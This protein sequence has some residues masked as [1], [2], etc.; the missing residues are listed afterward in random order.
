GVENERH[1][2]VR[3]ARGIEYAVKIALFRDLAGGGVDPSQRGSHGLDHRLV[4]PLVLLGAKILELLPQ[5]FRLLA[6][7]LEIPDQ[8]LRNIGFRL[9]LLSLELALEQLHL[10]DDGA[11]PLGPR[12]LKDCRALTLNALLHGRRRG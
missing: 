5:G 12:I 1:T 8:L 4:D 3:V 10:A 2:G 11:E 7:D 6:L 9:V